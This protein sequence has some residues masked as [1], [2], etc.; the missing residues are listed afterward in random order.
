MLFDLRARGRR[1][2]VQIVY[3]GLALIFLVSFVGLG[4]GG[5]FG[6]GGIF[7]AF[8]EN[9]GSSSANFAARVAAAQKHVQLH[10]TDSAAWAGLAEAQLHQASEPEYFQAATSSGETE[11]YTAKGKVLLAKVADSWNTYLKLQAHHPSSELAL[12]MVNVFS[13]TGLDQ[14]AAEM[15][16]LQIV[17]AGTAPS[18]RLYSA[19]AESA[20]KAGNLK[21]GDEASR[22]TVSLTPASERK[23]VKKYL[24]ELRKYPYSHT[25]STIGTN[26]NGALVATQAGKT[27]AV[28]PNGKGGYVSILPT[29]GSTAPAASGAK[30]SGKKK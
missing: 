5:G 8:T 11:A 29:T 4:I 9:K 25:P 1:R 12:K 15:R 16:A 14:P 7:N 20:Y 22:K 26:A 19:L 13:E 23:R 30:T 17:I 10:P 21:V 24:A 18:V 28:K 2:T 27:Y 3:L 6:S